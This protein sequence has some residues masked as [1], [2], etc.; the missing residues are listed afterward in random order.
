[1]SESELPIVDL[2]S[3]VLSLEQALALADAAYESYDSMSSS[4]PQEVGG[5]VTDIIANNF[6]SILR[7][8][9][10]V[11]VT[12]D[13]V[14]AIMD[15]LFDKALAWSTYTSSRLDT[16]AIRMLRDSCNLHFNEIFSILCEYLGWVADMN[17]ETG[18]TYVKG[19]MS[20]DI[21]EAEVFNQVAN[22][23][24]IDLNTVKIFL[25]VLIYCLR[26]IFIF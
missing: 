15:S 22:V 16:L 7:K 23:T 1:M 5:F 24:G 2:N 26:F 3:P 21:E 14:S 10:P 9:A 11:F 25:P 17:D 19:C 20:T 8:F 4:N 6:G 13:R 12:K 18:N